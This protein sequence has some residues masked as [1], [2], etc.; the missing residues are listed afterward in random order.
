MEQSAQNPTNLE[1]LI[2]VH[3]GFAT[4]A[5]NNLNYGGHHIKIDK[6]I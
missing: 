2:T 4:A 3:L 5:M 1:E 6:I